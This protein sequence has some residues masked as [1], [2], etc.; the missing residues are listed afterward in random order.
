MFTAAEILAMDDREIAMHAAGSYGPEKRGAMMRTIRALA[1]K[2]GAKGQ[3]IDRLRTM[4][5]E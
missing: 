5:R 4:T 3:I 2:A 1:E